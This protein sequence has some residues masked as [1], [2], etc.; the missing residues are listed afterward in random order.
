MESNE[1]RWRGTPLDMREGMDPF[2]V[3]EVVIQYLNDDEDVFTPSRRQEFK[4]YELHQMAAYIDAM[5]S[6]IRKGTRR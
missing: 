1:S 5:A 2:G 6:S 3:Q 4:S